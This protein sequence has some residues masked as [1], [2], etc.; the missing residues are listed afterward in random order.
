MPAQRCDQSIA[1]QTYH[2]SELVCKGDA[3]GAR[4]GLW[5]GRGARRGSVSASV[6]VSVNVNAN[7]NANAGSGQAGCTR[8][9]QS[10]A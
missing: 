10:G 7:A 9:G 1:L 8:Q 6:N 4:Q 2:R 3:V 5:G